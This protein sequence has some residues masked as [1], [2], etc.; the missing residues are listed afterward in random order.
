MW[1]NILAI[2]I[3]ISK[4]IDLHFLY[5]T[6]VFS[7]QHKTLKFFSSK[8]S[9]PSHLCPKLC[10]RLYLN[11]KTSSPSSSSSSGWISGKIAFE[12]C[13]YATKSLTNSFSS[14]KCANYYEKR[15]P[16]SVPAYLY[17]GREHW[18]RTEWPVWLCLAHVPKCFHSLSLV[19]KKRVV[20]YKNPHSTSLYAW[21]KFS[22]QWM[23]MENTAR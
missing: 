8:K 10:A 9:F 12:G 15:H 14:A 19:I 7:S 6:R 11:W 20:Y 13:H 22:S 4:R 5:R 1:Q 18:A 17:K 21:V 2:P 23:Y 3:K 16:R